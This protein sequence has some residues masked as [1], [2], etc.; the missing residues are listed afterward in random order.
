MLRGLTTVNYWASDVEA[1]KGWYTKLLGLK[2]YFE[3]PGG[4]SPAAYVEYRLG[5]SVPSSRRCRGPR[6]C[7]RLLGRGRRSGSL[8]PAP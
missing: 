4:G 8:R 3:R 1:A 7:G 5:D 2:P 6:R